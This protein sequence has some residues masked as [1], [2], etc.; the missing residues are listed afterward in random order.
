MMIWWVDSLVNG[1]LVV[2]SNT[3]MSKSLRPIPTRGALKKEEK[4]VIFCHIL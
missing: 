1:N 4:H 2:L 3:K